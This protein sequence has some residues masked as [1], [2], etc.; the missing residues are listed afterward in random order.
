MQFKKE[1]KTLFSQR[2]LLVSQIYTSLFSTLIYRS[3]IHSELGNDSI[4]VT[5]ETMAPKIVTETDFVM[6]ASPPNDKPFG[7]LC[8]SIMKIN[9]FPSSSA[10]NGNV[11]KVF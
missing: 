11:F 9:N 3:T 4:T 5:Y 10:A 6:I 1:C 8:N 2:K 7:S